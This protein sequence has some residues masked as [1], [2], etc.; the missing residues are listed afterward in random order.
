MLPYAEREMPLKGVFHQEDDLKHSSKRA[1]S[2]FQTNRVNVMEGPA[3]SS[4]FKLI[5]NLWGDIKNVV[6][7]EIARNAEELWNVVQ[8]SSAG[9]SVQRCH[10]LVYSMKHRC[11][12]LRN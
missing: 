12:S 1:A 10:K 11:D 9:I 4:D 6:S 5:E 2:R 3:Q 7:E 8:L